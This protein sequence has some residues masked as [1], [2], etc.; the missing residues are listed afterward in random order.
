MGWDKRDE[1]RA[2]LTLGDKFPP[3]LD[4]FTFNRSLGKSLPSFK[5]S[6]LLMNC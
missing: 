3:S 5:P 6:K 1:A 2:R 4:D